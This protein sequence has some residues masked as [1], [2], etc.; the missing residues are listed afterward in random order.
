MAA[1]VCKFNSAFLFYEAILDKNIHLLTTLKIIIVTN[2]HVWENVSEVTHFYVDTSKTPLSRPL[3]TRSRQN[4]IK[5]FL[6]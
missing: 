5:F 4:T 3:K 1:G 6:G 2:W